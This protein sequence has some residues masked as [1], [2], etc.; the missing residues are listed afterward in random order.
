MHIVGERSFEADGL[1]R[2]GVGKGDCRGVEGAAGNNRVFGD[3]F[4]VFQLPG[5]DG[6]S[7]IHIVGDDG[8]LDM[9][10]VDANLV[11]SARFGGEFQQ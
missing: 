7:A 1:F 4:G 6:F 5:I 11:G 9:S 10:E 8:V 2:R 3:G